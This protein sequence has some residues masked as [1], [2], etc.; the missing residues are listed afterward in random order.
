[1]RRSAVVAGTLGGFVRAYLDRVVNNRD[2]SG[3]DELVSPH[4]TGTGPGWPTTFDALRQFYALQAVE[5]PDWYINVDATLELAEIVVVRAH[6]GGSIKIDGVMR[7]K[8]VAW[9]A[10]Y[11]VQDQLIHEI[12]LLALVEL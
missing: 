4:Y 12:N 1:M 11:R 7:R 6:A 3:I 5:R 10:S 9:L 8:D 2:L